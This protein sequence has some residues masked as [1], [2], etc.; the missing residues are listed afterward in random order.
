MRSSY[1]AW[2]DAVALFEERSL[3][4]SAYRNLYQEEYILVPGPATVTG[5]LPLDDHDQ[6]PWRHDTPDPAT[7]YIVDGDLT[8][9][10]GLVDVDDGAAAL[11]VLGDLRA[12][13]VYLEG[14][15]KL[16]VR[17]DVTAR[18]FVGDMT[19]KLVMVHGDLRAT[20]AIFWN[21]FCPDLVTGVLHGRT[22]A[23]SYL[24]LST[25]PIGGLL[26]PAPGAPL[27]DLLVPE[28]LVDGA[29]GEDD[30]TEIGVRGGVL[31][32]RAL[33]GLPLTRTP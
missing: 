30:F 14:D 27:G 1:L 31:R 16:I 18:T 9:D 28:L 7:G 33:D 4:E 13:D 2:D 23:P 22:L 8:I 17:G 11:V 24:D 3:P 5:E 20:V 15:A 29:P 26:D 21:G 12:G 6:T 10:G 19:D 25:A 32:E